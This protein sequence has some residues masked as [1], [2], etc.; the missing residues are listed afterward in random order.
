MREGRKVYRVSRLR[1]WKA[2]RDI[3]VTRVASRRWGEKWMVGVVLNA[4]DLKADRENVWIRS[5]F[6]DEGDIIVWN[7]WLPECTQEWLR[8][9]GERGCKSTMRELW[10]VGVASSQCIMRANRN[11]EGSR[12]AAQR[13]GEQWIF[14][15]VRKVFVSRVHRKK[16]V[17]EITIIWWGRDYRSR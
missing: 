16:E 17:G 8:C 12:V 15:V 9:P 2:R 11:I 14:E 6:K 5:L 7:M 4:Y 10:K 3:D 13:W 1:T